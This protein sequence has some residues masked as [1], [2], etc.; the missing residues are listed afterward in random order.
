MWKKNTN[1]IVSD[2]MEDFNNLFH[3]LLYMCI[4]YSRSLIYLYIQVCWLDYASVCMSNLFSDWLLYKLQ[5]FF[6]FFFLLL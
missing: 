3:I 4:L 5:D 6:V 2:K 1:D